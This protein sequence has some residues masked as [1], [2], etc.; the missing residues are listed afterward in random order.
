[1]ISMKSRRGAA[2]PVGPACRR[3]ETINGTARTKR[4]NRTTAS[5]VKKVDVTLC[6]ALAR[7]SAS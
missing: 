7:R 6:W 1:M 5:T 3:A 4:S 2:G